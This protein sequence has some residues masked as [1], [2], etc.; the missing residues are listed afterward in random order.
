MVTSSTTGVAAESVLARSTRYCAYRERPPIAPPCATGANALQVASGAGVPPCRRKNAALVPVGV[1]AV[2]DSPPQSTACV[3][4][5]TRDTN[6]PAAAYGLMR[7]QSTDT[8]PDPAVKSLTSGRGG[9]A[10]AIACV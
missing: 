1:S 9:A 10:I 7:I 8:L 3:A 6:V 2:H 4:S 5:N